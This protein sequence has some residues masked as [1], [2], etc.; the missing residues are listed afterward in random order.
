MNLGKHQ[1][2]KE[3]GQDGG[4]KVQ[5]PCTSF[6]FHSY[7]MDELHNRIFF[8][9]VS[10]MN[11]RNLLFIFCQVLC[12]FNPQNSEQKLTTKKLSGFHNHF[13]LLAMLLTFVSLNFLSHSHACVYM[14]QI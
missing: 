8:L 14:L 12:M 5:Q 6:V 10:C 11:T 13:T 1:S 4:W 3:R 7:T 9:L 2:S